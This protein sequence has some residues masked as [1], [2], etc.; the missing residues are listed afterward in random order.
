MDVGWILC[1]YLLLPDCPGELPGV[2]PHRC[3]FYLPFKTRVFPA[4]L[5][6]WPLFAPIELGSL[7]HLAHIIW[8]LS[9]DWGQNGRGDPKQKQ[10][11]F[12][13]TKTPRRQHADDAADHGPT[14]NA[15]CDLPLDGAAIIMAELKAGFKTINSRFD[16]LTMQLHRMNERRH[17]TQL[18]AAECDIL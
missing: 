15:A 6:S 14:S 11:S 3:T 4:A 2:G 5:R 9:L 1:S 12:D 18:G 10:L 13:T 7:E 16:S 8:V 17:A